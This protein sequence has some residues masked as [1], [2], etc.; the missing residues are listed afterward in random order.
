MRMRMTID[1]GRLR[2]G[3]GGGEGRG[4]LPYGRDGDARRK[5]GIKP[6]KETNPSVAEAYADP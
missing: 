1:D 3:G 2:V 5:F 6:L 4:K